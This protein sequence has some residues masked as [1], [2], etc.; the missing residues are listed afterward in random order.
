MGRTGVTYI[1][2]KKRRRKKESLNTLQK[3]KVE[4]VSQSQQKA[5]AIDLKLTSLFT[6]IPFHFYFE[7]GAEQCEKN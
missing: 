4:V 3:R 7:V 1:R 2:K 5:F 6:K